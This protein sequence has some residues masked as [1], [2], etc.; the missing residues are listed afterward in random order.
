MEKSQM[1]PWQLVPYIL[2]SLA[3]MAASSGL[4]FMAWRRRPSPGAAQFAGLMLTVAVWLLGHALCLASASLRAKIFWEAVRFTGPI[5]A[6]VMWLMFVLWQD[7]FYRS[8]AVTKRVY[9]WLLLSSIPL[10]TLLLIWTNEAHLMVYDE[11]WLNSGGPFPVLGVTYGPW[12]YVHSV[13]SYLLLLF[14]IFLLYQTHRRAIKKR[15]YRSQTGLLIISALAL[16][17]ANALDTGGLNPFPYLALTPLA[18]TITGLILFWNLYRLRLFDIVPVARDLVIESI[19]DAVIALD[20]QDRIVDLNTAAGQILDR[21]VAKMIG[22]PVDL[23]FS[24]WPDL[25]ERYRTASETGATFDLVTAQHHFDA[26]LSLLRD[27]SNRTIGRLIVLHDV[28]ARLWAERALQQVRDDLERRVEERTSELSQVNIQLKR[29]IVE[30]E[31]A[32]ER[33]QRLLDQ[34]VAVNQLSLALGQTHDL[35]E[36]YYIIYDHARLL[37]DV[38]SFIVSS[39]NPQE[40]LIHAEFVIVNGTVLDAADL[41]PILLEEPGC[42]TQS[43]VIRTGKPLY[44]PDWRRAMEQTQVQYQINDTSND[45]FPGPPPPEAEPESTNSALLTPM[46]V[47]GETVGVMQVQSYQLDAYSSDD[48]DLLAALA[49]V[50]AVAIENVRLYTKE[51]QRAARLTRILEQ[52]QELDSLK[53]AVIQNVSHELRTPLAIAQGYAELLESGDL[54]ELSTGQQ[55]AMSIVARR[56][57]ALGGIIGNFTGILDAETRNLARESVNLADLVREPLADFQAIAEQVQLTLTAQVAPGLPPVWGDP[58]RLRQVVDN[59]LDN[60][61]KFTPAGGHITARLRREQEGVLLEVTDTGIGIPP[62]RLERVFERFYQVDGSTTRRY[63]GTGLG[64]ALVK[65]VVEAHR[66]RVGVESREGV[67]SVFVVWLPVEG[68]VGEEKE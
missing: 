23:A 29:E 48:L 55:E 42:G 50:S 32:E 47:R 40:R 28:T 58:F 9:S 6:P 41:P 56:I 26:R 8:L 67:G 39:Y 22:Q 60:A 36:I 37:M 49:N 16:L 34:Q 1:I 61:I 11:V 68:A 21:P 64:L 66:G 35:D 5:A 12:F 52:Q 33:S 4:A 65:E 53:D 20:D 62:D 51:Q 63:G 13:Y 54:G 38:V 14:G 19:E 30:R 43:R 2:P 3:A 15:L 18:F 25:V 45:I 24:H 44:V 27:R 31:L 59:L 7:V 10:A 57:R 46:R 17:A